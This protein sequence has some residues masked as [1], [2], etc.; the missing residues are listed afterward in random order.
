MES[1]RSAEALVLAYARASP[2]QVLQR[3]QPARRTVRE[4]A[5][6][7]GLRPGV[8]LVA[9][10]RLVDRGLVQIR[11]HPGGRLELLAVEPR[12]SHRD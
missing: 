5:H 11:F 10:T 8:C 2:V 12:P 1:T 6:E 9:L 3:G 4:L 7:L